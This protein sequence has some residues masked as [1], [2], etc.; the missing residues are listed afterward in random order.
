MKCSKCGNKTTW[1]KSF[2]EKHRL[3]C[4]VC[5]DKLLKKN[6]NDVMKTLKEI[7][8]KPIDKSIIV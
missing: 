1:D 4:P 2:G 6:D 7:F 5:F 8:Q 3:V